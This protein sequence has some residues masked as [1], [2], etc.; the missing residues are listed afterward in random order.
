MNRGCSNYD[1]AERE[2]EGEREA[3]NGFS[4]GIGYKNDINVWKMENS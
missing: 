3:V 4:N 2:R 1:E